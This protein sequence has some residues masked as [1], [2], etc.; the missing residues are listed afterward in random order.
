ML[1][2]IQTSHYWHLL[3]KIFCKY[4]Q[5]C[6]TDTVFKKQFKMYFHKKQEK[7]VREKK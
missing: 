2:I 7:V 1:V 6:E 4:I 5:N 3:K